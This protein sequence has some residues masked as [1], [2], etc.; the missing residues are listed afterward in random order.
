MSKLFVCCAV[1]VMV[2]LAP[3]AFAGTVSC[4]GLGTGASQGICD[5]YHSDTAYPFTLPWV[6]SPGIVV[7][8]DTI[9]AGGVG[10]YGEAPDP[11]N[12]YQ[13]TQSNW[14]DVLEFSYINGI[15]TVTLLSDSAP[16]PT[17]GSVGW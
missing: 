10:L 11:S 15:S 3:M 1:L 17:F 5:L 7:I 16:L 8:L 2:A 14:S 13:T 9:D 12:S 6:T 4:T